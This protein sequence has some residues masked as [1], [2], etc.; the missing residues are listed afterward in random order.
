MAG[1]GGM[2]LPA[3]SVTLTDG[4]RKATIRSAARHTWRQHL[5]FAPLKRP[6]TLFLAAMSCAILTV[7]FV[8]C[9]SDG[10]GG[11][12]GSGGGGAPAESGG[13]DNLQIRSPF[14]DYGNA[15]AVDAAG[16]I[17]IAGHIGEALPGQ[18]YAGGTDAFVRKLD[19]SFTESWTSQFGTENNDSVDAVAVDGS[20]TCISPAGRSASSR[21]TRRNTSAATPSFESMTLTGQR[22]GRRSSAPSTRQSRSPLRWT[23]GERVCGRTHGGQSTRIRECRWRS[24]RPG[25]G[26]ERRLP[27]KVRPRRTELWTQQFGHERHDEVL[28][29][30]LDGTG[31]VY[32]SGYTDASFEGYSNPKRTRRLHPQ[33]RSRWERRLDA[34]VRQRFCGGRPA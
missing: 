2:A 15:V 24:S 31:S 9:G 32:V 29:V 6:V 23:G 21:G 34:T 4:N 17:Y 10:G 11:N 22:G 12:G 14:D 1:V 28:G 18:T 3:Q 19:G 13:G 25:L 8:A 30:A 5:K 33:V 16:N 27:E 20:G 26:M 7:T